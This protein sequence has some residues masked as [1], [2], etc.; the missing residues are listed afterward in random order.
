MTEH[1]KALLMNR[2]RYALDNLRSEGVGYIDIEYTDE[3]HYMIDGKVF[4]I[5]VKD[6]ADHE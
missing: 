3:I 1:R 4:V 2:I 6:G 5:E